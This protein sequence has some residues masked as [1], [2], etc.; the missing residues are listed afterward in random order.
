MMIKTPCPTWRKMGL[1]T[2]FLLII[3]ASGAIPALADEN[4]GVG[5]DVEAEV[6]RATQQPTA[7]EPEP[8]YMIVIGFMVGILITLLFAGFLRR[9]RTATTSALSGGEKLG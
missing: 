7:T 3:M 8:L 5:A 1:T 4:F 6:E 2:A 9:R